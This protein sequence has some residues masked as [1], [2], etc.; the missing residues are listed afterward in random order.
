[1]NIVALFRMGCVFFVL[2]QNVT[3]A[4]GKIVMI[5][6]IGRADRTRSNVDKD[7]VAK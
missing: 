2:Q 1:M 3:F 5:A 6:V 4:P 7:Q